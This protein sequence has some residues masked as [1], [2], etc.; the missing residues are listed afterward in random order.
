MFPDV[1]TDPQDP[2]KSKL[3]AEQYE[4]C[5]LK[6]TERPFSGAYWSHHAD[7]AYRCVACGQLLFDS[8][9]KFDSGTGW[10]S[11]YQAVAEWRVRE[12][13]DQSYGMLRKE[14]MCSGCGSH[15]GHVFDDGPPPSG[16]RFCI[17]SA[18]LEFVAR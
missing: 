17:N 3:T 2:W 12:H 9:A 18:A 14:V 10:P 7:G 8:S 15:L 13:I 1:M 4:V 6:G 11:F 16:L 5:R